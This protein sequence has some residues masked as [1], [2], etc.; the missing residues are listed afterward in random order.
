MLV[1][2]DV[3]SLPSALMINEL[4]ATFSSDVILPTSLQTNSSDNTV[5]LVSLTSL[6]IMYL[7]LFSIVSCYSVL[8]HYY[9]ASLF[10]NDSSIPSRRVLKFSVLN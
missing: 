10:I 8:Y 1:G 5:H 2:S 3:G 7:L 9:V 4:N 6:V